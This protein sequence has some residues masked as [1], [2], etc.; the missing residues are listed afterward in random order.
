MKI[1][2]V[3]LAI[4]GVFGFSLAGGVTAS[5]PAQAAVQQC[6]GLSEE[7]CCQLA[8]E[9]NTIEALEEFLR[10]YPPGRSDSACA[11][12]AMT[13]LSGFG[14]EPPDHE[15]EKPRDGGNYGQ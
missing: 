6:N 4:F 15:G 5:Y 9:K 14:P 11:A 7:E 2:K 3:L 12:L 8:L 10:L 1:Q 13:A